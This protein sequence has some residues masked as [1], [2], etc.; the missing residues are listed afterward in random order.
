MR[1]HFA[2][3]WIAL[4]PLAAGPAAGLH[5]QENGASTARFRVETHEVVLDVAVT[6]KN[7]N[8]VNDLTRD[9]FR[10][11]EEKQV[12]T[13]HSFE[14]P[15]I[16]VLTP[17][18]TGNLGDSGVRNFGESPLTILVLD[19]LATKFED[20]AYARFRLT[21]YLDRQ[22]EHLAQPTMLVVLSN[23]KM[24]RLVDWTQ[25]KQ[26]II[27]AIA[28]RRPDVPYR[29]S[30]D[31]Q[32]AAELLSDSLAALTQIAQA[33]AGEHG[34][35]NVI[36][37][38]HGFPA[39]DT[40]SLDPLSAD[41]ITN[42]L[43]VTAKILSDARLTLYTIDPEGLPAYASATTTDANPDGDSAV[44]LPDPSDMSFGALTDLTGGHAFSLRNDLDVAI[45]LSV[46]AGSNYYTMSYIP[47]N[48]LY[49]GKYRAIRVEIL[50]H[51][52]LI[53]HTRAG[54]YADADKPTT[55]DMVAF[56]LTK[57]ATTELPYTG[58][59]IA[60]TE[61]HPV[62]PNAGA[63]TLHI[64]PHGLKWDNLPNGDASVEF[65]IAVCETDDHGNI[66]SYTVKELATTAQSAH[67]NQIE[68]APLLYSVPVEVSARAARL[69]IIVRDVT[70]GRIGTADFGPAALEQIHFTGKSKHKH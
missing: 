38:G 14:A 66:V 12:Q 39:L 68:N 31:P 55:P 30:G 50:H 65:A 5:A 41:I 51:P 17:Q 63:F 34:R 61:F 52:G 13:L 19:E 64:E 20:M 25:D 54:Y 3:V 57:A 15:D 60:A 59:I 2:L 37:L 6:D 7:G 40:D 47:T 22:P 62:Q 44:T 45:D 49:D 42:A 58:L 70:N 10:V 18:D 8:T 56:E 28:A 48:T 33:N 27:K 35:K 24:I 1:F 4:L 46:R 69:R 53:A 32:A 67:V 26:Q 21:K 36:W 9:D 16:H 29:I 23:K 11:I 43:H